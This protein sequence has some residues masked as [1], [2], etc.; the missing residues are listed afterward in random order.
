MRNFQSSLFTP[1]LLLRDAFA[2]RGKVGNGLTVAP[3]LL[4]LQPLPLW[5]RLGGII[6]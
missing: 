4:F 2:Q 1:S 3:L 5:N 6:C